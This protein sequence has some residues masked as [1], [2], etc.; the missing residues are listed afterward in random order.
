M[1][2]ETLKTA[3][4]AER[5]A[6]EIIRE[7]DT[8]CKEILNEARQQAADRQKAEVDAAT[9]T[10]QEALEKAR[11][12]EAAAMEEA[13]KLGNSRVFNIIVLGI[14]AQH[15]DF[16][17]EDWLTVISETVPEK[18]IDINKKAFE[19]GYNLNK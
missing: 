6:D 18:T 17:K 3:R 14:A 8:A 15:M 9:Q 19:V 13:K 10:A 2:E 4:E 1:V 5:K 11:E 12:T 16:K 7:A